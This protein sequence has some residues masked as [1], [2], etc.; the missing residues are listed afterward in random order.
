[1]PSGFDIERFDVVKTNQPYQAPVIINRSTDMSG[2]VFCW[3]LL[4]FGIVAK[5][6]FKI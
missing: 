6:S 5:P 3:A 4:D 1:M 2:A